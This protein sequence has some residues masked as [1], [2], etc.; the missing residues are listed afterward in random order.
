M[1]RI[2]VYR[3]LESNDC[4]ASCIQMIAHYYG[5]KYSL[6]TIKNLCEISRL[7]FSV[8]DIIDT[9]TKIGLKAYSVTVNH[10][11]IFSMPTPAILYF[12]R[13]HFVVLEKINQKKESFIIIDPDEG[14]VRLN[15][16]EFNEKIFIN[17]H[18]V[19]IVLAPDNNF[20]E[21]NKEL[22]EDREHTIWNLTQEMLRQYK[23]K[24]SFITILTLFSMVITWILP[25]IFRKTVDE[26]IALKNINLVWILLFSQLL[27]YI[28]F[29]ITSSIAN[30]LLSK[31][32]FKL[33]IDLIAKYLYK[34][35]DLPMNYFDTRFNS[36]LI[37]RLSDQDR[38]NNFITDTLGT[39]LLTVLNLLVFSSIL[40]YFSGFV[41]V[42]FAISTVLS[43]LYTILF[44]E[45]R[46]HIDYSLFSLYSERRNSIYETIMGMPDIKINSSQKIRISNWNRYQQRINKLNLK[47]IVLDTLFSE[48]VGF[49][50][51]L[52]NLFVTGLCAFLV[53][54]EKMTIGTMMTTSFLLGQLVSPINQ[55][56]SF[57]RE[58]QYAKLSHGRVSDVLERSNEDNEQKLLINGTSL[59]KGIRF[60]YV[61]FKYSGTHSPL[62]LDSINL[63]IEHKKITAIVGVSGSGKTTLLRLL[64]GFYFPNDGAILL[65]DNDITKINCN[66]WRKKC[67]VVMQDGYIFSGTIAENIAISEGKP[68]I[69]KLEK[70][71][72]LACL[73]DFIKDMPMGFHTKIGET[74]LPISGGQKQRIL[75]ARAVYKNPDYIFFDEAT[76]SLDANN[77]KEI[78]N[79]LDY[80]FEGKT[81]MIIAHRLSTVKNADKIVV[82]DKGKIVEQGTHTELTALKGKYFE[83]V[84]NQLELGN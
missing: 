39:M 64:L 13:G 80:F 41:F 53:I 42:I 27:F 43:F 55:L 9:C 5:R 23:G 40:F 6:K 35:I 46:K 78:L 14:R 2:P 70:A 4:G 69:E 49:I 12:R 26:G 67:G 68:D 84:K 52:K 10:K 29:T 51:S 75:I 61:N 73:E 83:L 30:F 28:G 18:C 24:F 45:R 11:E 71:V 56:L 3:Q 38:I 33:G 76:N 58:L 37:Q 19:A 72:K 15:N 44:V 50:G 8:K 65:G 16:E 54:Q 62:I 34:I 48:G 74:G 20:H 25:L 82:L 63:K 32:G 21:I 66:E 81:V 57:S 60:D 17:E 36:D 79:N 7:G 1:R 22:K 31:T 59:Y 47:S 77:E